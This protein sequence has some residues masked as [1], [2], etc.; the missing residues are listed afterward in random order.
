MENTEFENQKRAYSN[1]ISFFYPDLKWTST[2]YKDLYD[3]L[4]EGL[5][6]TTISLGDYFLEK[7]LISLS[8]N[9]IRIENEVNDYARNKNFDDI[10]KEHIF[11]YKPFL[12]NRINK[13]LEEYRLKKK[14]IIK[15]EKTITH[16]DKILKELQIIEIVFKSQMNPEMHLGSGIGPARY[17]NKIFV[18]SDVELLKVGEYKREYSLRLEQ[19][20]NTLLVVNELK[21]IYNKSFELYNYFVNNLNNHPDKK[22]FFVGQDAKQQIIDST[23]YYHFIN[24]RVSFCFF[25]VEPDSESMRAI[26]SRFFGSSFRYNCKNENLVNFCVQLLD[27]I[28]LTGILIDKN[29]EIIEI[30]KNIKSESKNPFPLIFTGDNDKTFVLF[31]KFVTTHIIDKYTDFSFIFQQMKHN[32]YISDIKHLKFM[33]WLNE[34]NYINEK[35]Y[36]DFKEKNT[37]KSLNKC[38]FSTRLNLYL[39]LKEEIIPNSD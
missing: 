3:I 1:Y 36:E 10:Q 39:K 20:N 19:S 14:P 21:E 5:G 27:F 15:G 2:I 22:D 6:L 8:D 9:L 32:G 29:K 4:D 34:N 23:G 13:L 11:Y 35:E 33:K 38:S 17:C 16:Y 37:F 18:I 12:E 25:G 30:D 7:F 24:Y 26:N 28:K 31:Q